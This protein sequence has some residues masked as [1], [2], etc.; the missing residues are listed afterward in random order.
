MKKPKHT[1]VH[2]WPFK[3]TLVKFLKTMNFAWA[4]FNRDNF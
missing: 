2:I 4:Q 3:E 1:S